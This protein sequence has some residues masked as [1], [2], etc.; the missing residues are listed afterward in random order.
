MW[1]GF[2]G[3]GDRLSDRHAPLSSRNG[4]TRRE[5]APR[6]RKRRFSR[7]VGG[8]GR[9]RVGSRPQPVSPLTHP[10]RRCPP[11]SSADVVSVQ[12]PA[13]GL[14]LWALCAGDGHAS[15]RPPG[16]GGLGSCPAPAGVVLSL[17]Q[18]SRL[19]TAS[20]PRCEQGL[21]RSVQKM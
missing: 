15:R 17:G 2:S 20:P 19:L 12:R 11:H 6:R 21:K 4:L 13:R 9:A 10:E 3:R 14:E 7:A 1:S 8:E 18:N 5:T 16:P